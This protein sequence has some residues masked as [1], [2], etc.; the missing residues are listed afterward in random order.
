MLNPILE[1][2]YNS[3]LSGDPTV[4][5]EVKHFMNEKAKQ[6][7][8][9]QNIHMIDYDD[10]IGIL[11]ISNALYNNGANIILPL[12]DDL[13]DAL[14]NL[15]KVT[16]IPTPVGAPPISFK[17][18]VKVDRGSNLEIKE[19]GK[20]EVIQIVPKDKMMYF[21]ALVR[22]YTFPIKEDFE[23][24]HD[25]TLVKK[26]SR[27]V[28]H[29]YDMCGTLDKCKF[30]LKSEA[31][32]SGVLDDKTVQIFERD[33]L[34]THA[35]MGIIDPNHIKLIASLKY[36]GVSVE[37]EVQGS[38]ISFA[39]TRG[40]TDNN[41]ASDLTPILGGM[42][43]HRA[44]GKVDDT[45]R[46][47]I[48][49]EY[50][51]TNYNLQRIERDF[52]KKYAN[53]RNAVIGLLGG[54][55]ARMYRDYLTPIPLESSLNVDRITELEFLNKYYTK[56]TSMRYE[57]I[58]GDYMQ[59]LFMVNQFVKEAN[60]LRDF[61]GFQYDGIVIEYADKDI[62]ERLGKRGAIPR[63]AIAIKFNP[64][65]RKSTFTHYTYSVGQDGRITPMAHFKPVEFF[66]AIHDKTT[67][68]SLKR[69]NELA[70]R[71]GDKVDLTLVN[72]VIVYIRK[73]K[74]KFNETNTAP[75]EEFP[76]TC[77][78]CGEPLYVTDSGDS[79][80]CINFYCR[81]KVIGRLT[82]FLKKLNS[83]DFSSE[84]IRALDV[85]WVRDLF[86]IPK[87][88]LV[89][90]LGEVNSIKFIERLDELKKTPYPD[91]RIL[92]A[93]GFTSIAL[94]TWKIILQNVSLN[95]LLSD[96]ENTL[97]ALV[98]VKGIGAKTIEVLGNEIP[99]FYDD[100]KFICDNFNIIYTEV[101][102]VSDKIQ[103]RFSGL[104][105]HVLNQRFIDAGFDSRED[106]GVTNST[107]ILVVP[108]N[109]LES[110]NVRK[111]FKAK[112]KNFKLKTG[113]S[114]ESGIGWN[115]YREFDSYAPMILNASDADEY[116]K[117][118]NK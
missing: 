42:E 19:D 95:T 25:E 43:F 76:E 65:K 20:K 45:E 96:T 103:V 26:K 63:Y 24:H 29:T 91:Y 94:E 106:S 15:C 75:L 17:E 77:P 86:N 31:L 85:T 71:P 118:F 64:L 54:L 44:K 61:M 9:N 62:R 38:K 3:I 18:E 102:N 11:K 87:S 98:N 97:K 79:A 114:L 92:G 46:F 66:G 6:V 23:V 115:N 21:D 7:I 49:F 111:A 52:K 8:K 58:E 90:K 48:K 84:S 109:G 28:A 32:E 73:S 50:I 39:C 2:A 68:H 41:E 116:L 117:T 88:V 36:D 35:N 112:E 55:D 34:G 22:N 13:Y 57:I 81:E 83:K 99:K 108:Y 30:V 113:L 53:P 1:D 67:A 82:N 56:D 104:R 37:E 101:G 72:D 51:V 47:G 78:C 5:E 40:D 100:I 70:L 74:D 107:G 14:V 16:N 93:I 89:E 105:D 60:D 59:V 80:V 27:N 110:G 10:I 33:F 4:S 12:N 69:F